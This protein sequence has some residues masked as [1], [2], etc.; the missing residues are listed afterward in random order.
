MHLITYHVTITDA[1]M[2]L[3]D[4]RDVLGKNLKSIREAFGYTQAQVAEI[5][6][7][8]PT[9]YSRWENGKVWPTPETINKL[10]ELFAC[11]PTYFYKDRS[12]PNDMSSVEIGDIAEGAPFPRLLDIVFNK[13]KSVPDDIIEMSYYQ[14]PSEDF[15]NHVRELFHDDLKKSIPP[16]DSEHGKQVTLARQELLK[17]LRSKP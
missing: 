12:L 8:E 11:S 17:N 15:W 16:H 1:K 2:Q 3:M 10:A 14:R 4:I 6:N 13:I 9:S 7:F 5:C